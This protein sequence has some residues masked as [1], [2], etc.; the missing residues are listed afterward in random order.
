MHADLPT[1]LELQQRDKTVQQFRDEMA[2][3]DPEIAELDANLG[4]CQER[5]DATRKAALEAGEYR[6]ELEE[7]IEEFKQLQERKRQKLEWVRGAKEA[8]T[9]MAELDLGKSVLAKEEAEWVRSADKVQE[10]ELRAAEAEKAVQETKDGQG[11]RRDEI[12]VVHAEAQVK[13]TAAEAERTTVAAG[14]PKPLLTQYERIRKGRAPF[15]VYALHGGACGHCFTAV[16]LHRRQE[17][18][19]GSRIITC[20]ACGVMIYEDEAVPSE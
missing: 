8:A 15:A 7:K 2:A 14:V 6:T 1:L 4:A 10:T 19:N 5:L 17:L 12:A 20:E 16:P 9:L 3:L 11:A 18:L 13:I